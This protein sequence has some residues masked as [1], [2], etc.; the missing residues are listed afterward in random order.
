MKRF[1]IALISVFSFST[2]CW[3]QTR[4][5]D[6]VFTIGQV[7]KTTDVVY[8]QNYYFMPYPPASGSCNPNNPEI[9]DL[10]MD[11]Y[12]PPVSDTAQNRP[13]IIICHTGSFLPR[14]QN[15]YPVGRKDDS[16]VVE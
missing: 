13:L 1:L 2:I 12:T 8:G 4:Y 10:Q 5:L 6:D 11:V 7:V 14:F 15:G 9:A 3:S 16:T